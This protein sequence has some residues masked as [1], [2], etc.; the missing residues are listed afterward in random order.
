[1]LLLAGYGFCCFLV[2]FGI[3]FG[4]GFGFGFGGGGGGDG[5]GNQD[6]GLRA[7]LGEALA[8]RVGDF[9]EAVGYLR[10]GEVS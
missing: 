5:I 2:G 3:I 7:A 9:E 6:Q 1:M 4:F 8:F 10:G